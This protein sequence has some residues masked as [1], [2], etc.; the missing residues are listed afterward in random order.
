MIQPSKF[1]I[2]AY[3]YGSDSFTVTTLDDYLPQAQQAFR[4]GALYDE[5]ILSCHDS[6]ESASEQAEA[7]QRDRDRVR[8]SP[9]ERVAGYLRRVVLWLGEPAYNRVV[10]GP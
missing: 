8:L 6:R 2:V 1:W 4:E 5:T 7:F 3:S 9:E 10:H